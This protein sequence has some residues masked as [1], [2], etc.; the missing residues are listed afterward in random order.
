[1]GVE[2]LENAYAPYVQ[3]DE[4]FTPALVHHSAFCH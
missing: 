3:H 2:V 1:M 4:L